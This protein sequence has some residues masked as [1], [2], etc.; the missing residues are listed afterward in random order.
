MR[1]IAILGGGI[2]GLTAAYELEKARRAGADIDWQL[3]EASNRLGGIIET[4]RI[5]TPEGE[6]ILEGG[7]DG[8]VSDKPW[9]R[10]LAIEL[11]LEADL[12][13]SND[14]TRKTDILK[15]SE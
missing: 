14:A 12:I 13:Y 5:P 2:S 15:T 10:E 8:W 1:T 4:T 11:G 7:P 3:F 6:Y 9:A